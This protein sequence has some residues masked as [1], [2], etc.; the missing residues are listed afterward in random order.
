MYVVHAPAS[1]RPAHHSHI[2]TVLIEMY[3]SYS[4]S[5]DKKLAMFTQQQQSRI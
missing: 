1:K 5:T 4:A 2:T 3:L